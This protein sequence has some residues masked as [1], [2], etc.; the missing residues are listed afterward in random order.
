MRSRQQHPERDSYFCRFTFG[1]FFALLILE[2]FTIFFVFYLGARYGRDVLGLD[3]LSSYQTNQLASNEINNSDEVKVLTTADPEAQ[4]ALKDMIRKNKTPA[5]QDRIRQMLNDAKPQDIQKK[6]INDTQ[7]IYND[8]ISTSTQNTH[9]TTDDPYDKDLTDTYARKTIEND[10][11]SKEYKG[12]STSTVIRVK[13]PDNAKYSV[14]VG[15]YP[16]I[17][18]ATRTIENWKEKGY[19]AYMMIVDIPDRGRW[20]RV[21]IGGFQTR[22]DAKHYMTDLQANEQTEAIVVLNEK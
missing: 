2:V 3:H 20:Y 7:P 12:A 17:Q 10:A 1:Q 22:G 6:N 18:E 19:P 8:T 21:R 13:S 15:S 9:T 11:N 5:L 4:D 14:Q 16:S